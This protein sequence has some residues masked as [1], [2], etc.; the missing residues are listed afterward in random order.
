MSK[1]PKKSAMDIIFEIAEKVGKMDILA[2]ISE[3]DSSL[4]SH[5][6]DEQLTKHKRPIDCELSQ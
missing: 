2:K 6:R 3:V 4:S 5:N 1:Q